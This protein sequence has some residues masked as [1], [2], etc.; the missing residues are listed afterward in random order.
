[1]GNELLGNI[2]GK[3]SNATTKE[4]K[5]I[6]SILNGEKLNEKN[7]DFMSLKETAEYLSCSRT[8]LWKLCNEGTVKEHP[9]GGRIL[10]CKSELRK[11]ILKSK[12]R[13]RK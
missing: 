6:S 11:S 1:M 3:V 7:D 4:L 10:I 12:K 8:H 13:S 5:S 9:V 2:L